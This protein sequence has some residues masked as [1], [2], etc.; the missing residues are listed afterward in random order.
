MGK[1]IFV[2]DLYGKVKEIKPEGFALPSGQILE[3]L[4]D[5]ALVCEEIENLGYT[6]I[7]I[8]NHGPS[9]YGCLVYR[10]SNPGES[11]PKR[12]RGGDDF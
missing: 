12:L 4:K 10:R 6:L 8:Y 7:R 11:S 3:K 9:S 2:Y 1:Y 5:V